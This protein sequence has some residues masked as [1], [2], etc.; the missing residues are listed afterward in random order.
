MRSSGFD[1][2]TAP[3]RFLTNSRPNLDLFLLN[4]TMQ[5]D[6]SSRCGEVMLDCVEDKL[7]SKAQ[8]GAPLSG[9]TR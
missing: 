8:V 5:A 7:R 2:E 9:N 4:W 3:E 1:E 6:C